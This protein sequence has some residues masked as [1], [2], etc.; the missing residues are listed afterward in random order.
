[1]SATMFRRAVNDL[2]W[3]AIWYSLGL[4]LYALCMVAFYPSMG[5]SAAYQ[6]VLKVWP[7]ELLHVFGISDFG[8]FAGFM[9]GELLNLMWP[10]IAAAFLITVGTATVAQEVERGTIELWLSIPLPRWRL[11]SSKVVALLTGAL[12]LVA[13]TVASIAVG[14]GIIGESLT[15]GGLLGLG[16]ELLAFSIAVAG[17]SAFFSSLS[18]TR[19]RAAGLAAGLTVAFYLGFVVAGFS[20]RWSWLQHF[21]IFSAYQP[22]QALATGS[23]DLLG[24]AALL[25]LGALSAATALLIFERRDAL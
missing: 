6:Q 3:T 22:Q 10:L 20:D 24:A 5:K 19:G 23:A 11:L 15:V 21:S 4:A 2:R 17:Y 12:A 9:G 18:S 16:L 25:A 14:A 7:E 8:T 1:M 13:A